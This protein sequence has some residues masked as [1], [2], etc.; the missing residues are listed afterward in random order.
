MRNAD[1]ESIRAPDLEII[2]E[3][4]EFIVDR[5]ALEYMELM[6]HMW[7]DPPWSMTY[8][9]IMNIS[10]LPDKGL[11]MSIPTSTTTTGTATTTTPTT[12]TEE[13][14]ITPTTYVPP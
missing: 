4:L 5:E 11:I 1:P 8:E 12:T 10:D 7:K 13:V 2:G 6:W 9:V 14:L 3:N